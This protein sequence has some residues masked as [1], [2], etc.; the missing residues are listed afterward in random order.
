MKFLRRKDR[1][2]IPVVYINAIKQLLNDDKEVGGGIT[3]DPSNKRLIKL[4][5]FPSSNKNSIEFKKV[6]DIEFHTH[7]SKPNNKIDILVSKIPSPGDI[8]STFV[9]KREE[10]VITRGYIFKIKIQDKDLFLRKRKEIR[11]IAEKDFPTIYDLYRDFLSNV[12]ERIRKIARKNVKDAEKKGEIEI[13]NEVLRLWK[14]FLLS[15][16]IYIGKLE[17]DDVLFNVY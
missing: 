9:S 13:I 3:L 16:G 4:E 6:Y 15:Y 17:K 14:D 1:I 10:F 8:A 11:D 2:N 7:P 12:F 5:I